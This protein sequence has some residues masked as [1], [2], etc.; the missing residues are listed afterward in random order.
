[1]KNRIRGG[2]LAAEAV[3]YLSFLAFDLLSVHT[4][5]SVWIKFIS[6]SLAA[7]AGLAVRERY[8]TP[9]LVLTACADVFLLLLGRDYLVGIGLFLLVQALYTLRLVWPDGNV[10]AALAV[11]AVPAAAAALLCAR[12]GAVECA[13]AAYIVWFAINLLHAIRKAHVTRERKPI[14]FAVGMALFFCCDLCVGLHNLPQNALSGFAAIA[15]WAFY[16]PG[17]ILI[18]SS[19]ENF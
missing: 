19:A 11:R 1:M 17:Q 8:V 10:R 7:A 13:A 18:L 12:S 16:L 9:A 3:L 6:I 15:M 14:R 5:W 4:Q 2:F